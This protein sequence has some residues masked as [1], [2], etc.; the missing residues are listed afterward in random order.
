MSSTQ[1]II[2]VISCLLVH[3]GAPP[4]NM[5]DIDIWGDSTSNSVHSE[6]AER[7][8][9]NV[10]KSI[11]RT[12][13]AA[14]WRQ[15]TVLGFLSPPVNDECLSGD[16]RRSGICLNVYE[17]RLQGG[18]SNGEC[19]LG[20]GVCCVF[21][22][23]CDQE[24]FN[25]IT[26]IVSPSFPASLARDVKSCK[27]KIKMID[28]DI[29]QLRFDFI[30]FQLGQPNRWTGI[31]EGDLFSLTGSV[32]SQS[33]FK[34]CGQNSGQHIYYNVETLAKPGGRQNPEAPPEPRFVEV[35]MNFT[36]TSF[37][38]RL[39]EIRVS[40]IPFSQKAP[41][42]CLQYFTGNE[43][44]IQTFNYAENGRHLANQNY[45]A[46]IR[47]ETGMCSIAYEPCNPYSFRIGQ[48][49]MYY[50]GYPGYGGFPGAP[51]AGAG[52]FPAGGGA[53][54][55]GSSG[56][57]PIGTVN[58][59]PPGSGGVL[60]DPVAAETAPNG[61]ADA[62]NGVAQADA[63]GEAAGDGVS[64][65]DAAAAPPE[66]GSDPSDV[67][68][69]D[70]IVDDAADEAEG[71]GGGG[72]FSSLSSLFSFRGWRSLDDRNGR[73]FFPFCSDR[74]TLPCIVEDFIGASDVSMCRPVHCGNSL[75][76]PG[77]TPCRVETSV[78]PFGIGFHFGEGVNKGSPE[79]NIGACLRWTQMPCL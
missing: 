22:A 39:W 9:S 3:S 54:G 7:F 28:E 72:F 37:L 31:C 33:D 29:S 32:S 26:Y 40:Q 11:G 30:H 67:V 36:D 43:G 51:G 56:G 17:C 48:R 16:G 60:S 25:N 42:G 8:S 21:I 78:T 52:G 73:Q 62:T 47:Q 50:G 27:L 63:P 66:A 38:S 59:A 41:T 20:F 6:G 4:P 61:A 2:F 35:L 5:V 19:A 14:F 1:K 68:E 10:T 49:Q 24:V 75:C 55:L 65:D 69:N 23:T 57:V 45:R 74:M 77:Q 71:S 58:S 79:E 76:P 64:A 12:S 18:T 44:L 15:F 46:C 53:G 13:K 34:I 70:E